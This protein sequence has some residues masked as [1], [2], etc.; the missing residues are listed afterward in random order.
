MTESN[1]LVQV[2]KTMKKTQ[3]RLDKSE[4]KLELMATTLQTLIKN[5]SNEDG[6]KPSNRGGEDDKKSRRRRGKKH[7]SN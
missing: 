7:S 1:E 3:I 5:T 6:E 4:N 2:A